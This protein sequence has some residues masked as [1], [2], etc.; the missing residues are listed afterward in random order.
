MP[1]AIPQ[2]M[3]NQQVV[4]TPVTP[5]PNVATA[6]ATT[7]VNTAPIAG[8]NFVTGKTPE[9]EKDEEEVWRL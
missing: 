6:P 9:T 7:P 5:M 2:P 3:P 8:L 1:Q 4:Q